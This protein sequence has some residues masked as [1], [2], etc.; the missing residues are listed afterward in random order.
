QELLRMG[1]TIPYKQ[2]QALT[3]YIMES[4][5]KR[6]ALAATATGWHSPALFVMPGGVIGDGDV[7]FQST[8]AGSQ[9]Y[10]TAGTPEG[11]RDNVAALCRGNP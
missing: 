11:W 5:P 10:A 4:A 1:V 3:E 9:E 6:R 8:E 7:V 2:R